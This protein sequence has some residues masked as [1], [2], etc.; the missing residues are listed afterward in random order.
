MLFAE[1]INIFAERVNII[2]YIVFDL[3]TAHSPISA[4]SSHSVVFRLPPVYF[5]LL[6]YIEDLTLVVVSYKIYETSL[7]RV[8]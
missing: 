6:L 5:C 3:I 4:Q 1:R 8:S 2:L 7:L